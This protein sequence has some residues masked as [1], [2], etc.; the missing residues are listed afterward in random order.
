MYP[1]ITFPAARMVAG[2]TGMFEETES[3]LKFKAKVGGVQ[4]SFNAFGTIKD[5]IKSY[6][7]ERGSFLAITAE[8][9][10][11]VRLDKTVDESYNVLSAVPVLGSEKAVWPT[12]Y[13]PSIKVL[14]LKQKD[15]EKAGKYWHIFAEDALSYKGIKTTRNI[16]AW[17]GSMAEVVERLK[18][19]EGSRIT[20]VAQA[21]YSLAE[22]SKK[23]VDYTL[24]SF[25][26]TT[27]KGNFKKEEES[28]RPDNAKTVIDVPE[29][30]PAPA[31]EEVQD[32]PRQ[33]KKN[34]SI[35]FDPDEFE[36]MFA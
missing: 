6:N 22:G 5:I 26:Y 16:Y 3:C 31:F 2:K 18:L 14:A 9:K 25:E 24:L 32:M 33:E 23:R 20:A 35:E 27:S 1:I 11:F 36:K 34:V 29:T 8:I 30:P 28:E 12:V 19:K 21:R 13:F 15:G 7:L 17:S 10:P 4:I